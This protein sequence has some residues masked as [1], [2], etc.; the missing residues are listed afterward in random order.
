MRSHDEYVPGMA[1]EPDD[2]VADGGAAT[3][4]GTVRAACEGDRET[5]A[6]HETAACAGEALH[7]RYD[8]EED[9]GS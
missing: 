5:L 7:E 9:G 8:Q 3:D 2:G 1:A 6:A 4:E